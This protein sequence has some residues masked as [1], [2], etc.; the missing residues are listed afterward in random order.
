VY[1]AGVIEDRVGA[2]TFAVRLLLPP[3]SPGLPRS[4]PTTRS[5]ALQAHANDL[6]LAVPGE[7]ADD[8]AP[9]NLV[10]LP[11]A[12]E[13][14]VLHALRLRYER[15]DRAT[16]VGDTLVLLGADPP[17]DDVREMLSTRWRASRRDGAVS[18][19]LGA[20]AVADAASGRAAADRAA[21]AD[22]RS[23]D[24]G[25]GDDH[26]GSA[27][28]VFEAAEVALARA[29]REGAG[30]S[31]VLLGEAG[32]G[33]TRAAAAVVQYVARGLDLAQVVDEA[34]RDAAEEVLEA[35]GEAGAPVGGLSPEVLLGRLPASTPAGRSPSEADA[36]A[37]ATT[38]WTRSTDGAAAEPGSGHSASVRDAVRRSVAHATTSFRAVMTLRPGSAGRDASAAPS[39]LPSA[40]RLERILAAAT[41][42]RLAEAADVLPVPDLAAR[43]AAADVVVSSFTRAATSS[44]PDSSRCAVLTRVFVAVGRGGVPAC[45]SPLAP[46]TLDA[47]A[48][49]GAPVAAR[50]DVSPVDTER[51]TH[52]PPGERSF[53]AFYQLCAGLDAADA[54]RLC[55]P[56]ARHCRVLHRGGVIDVSGGDGDTEADAAG[57]ARLDAA[58]AALGSSGD[59]RYGISHVLAAILALG[60]V[61][62]VPS[63]QSSGAGRAG[64]HA[65]PLPP[66]AAARLQAS[67]V[68]ASDDGISDEHLACVAVPPDAAPDGSSP[69]E[70]RRLHE[71]HWA[72]R[73]FDEAA[74]LLGLPRGRLAALLTRKTQPRPSSTSSRSPAAVPLLVAQAE[75]RRDR[76][77]RALYGA[78]LDFVVSRVNA[79]LGADHPAVAIATSAA[80][81]GGPAGYRAEVRRAAAAGSAAADGA[82][83]SGAGARSGALPEEARRAVARVLASGATGVGPVPGSIEGAEDGAA[84]VASR[85]AAVSV[86]DVPGFDSRPVRSEF[87]PP[88]D[89][90]FDP[91]SVAAGG[92]SGLGRN[93][94]WQLLRNYGAERSESLFAANRV[95]DRAELLDGEGLLRGARPS[96]S[97]ASHR[98]LDGHGVHGRG[99]GPGPDGPYGLESNEG[100]LSLLDAP[101]IGLLG[102]L[103]ESMQYAASSDADVLKKL[104]TMHRRSHCLNRL[105]EPLERVAAATLAEEYMTAEDAVTALYGSAVVGAAPGADPD[106]SA[107]D[108]RA[109]AHAVVVRQ[110]QH[111][112]ALRHSQGHTPYDSL[113]MLASNR[114]GTC[115]LSICEAVMAAGPA[116]HALVPLLGSVMRAQTLRGAAPD[117]DLAGPSAGRARGGA[118]GGRRHGP[119]AAA[120]VPG[121]GAPSVFD[122]LDTVRRRGDGDVA[123][124]GTQAPRAHDAVAKLVHLLDIAAGASAEPLYVRCLLPRYGRPFPA[125]DETSAAVAAAAVA[126]KALAHQ[127]RCQSLVPA[128]R[129]AKEG[130]SQ[131][132]LFADFY[133]VFVVVLPRSASSHLPLACPRSATPLEGRT[134]CE[135][136]VV[137][138]WREYSGAL[139]GLDRDSQVQLG[140]TRV[141]LRREAAAALDTLRSVRRSAMDSAAVRV[142]AFM[143]GASGRAQHVVARHGVTRLQAAVRGRPVRARFL[144]QRGAATAIG[145]VWRGHAA[146][147]AYRRARAGLSR[148]KACWAGRKA[149]LAYLHGLRTLRQL[150]AAAAGALLRRQLLQRYEAAVAIQRS[151]RGFLGRNREFW[152]EVH[153]SLL[154]Q[155][156][157]RGF[158]WRRNNRHL[159]LFV[160]KRVVARLAV[161]R[162]ARVQAVVRGTGVRRA[163]R[164][165]RGSAVKVQRW[166]RAMLLWRGL[167]VMREAAVAVQR[168]MRTAVFRQR[169]RGSRERRMLAE[170]SWRTMQAREQETSQL[171]H[172]LHRV[173]RINA[174]KH[175]RLRERLSESRRAE[176]VKDKW[177][178]SFA[179]FGRVAD[180]MPERDREHVAHEHYVARD[181]LVIDV[182][183]V[184]SV[185]HSYPGGWT[186]GLS[187][188]DAALRERGQ[189]VQTVAL[190]SHHTAVLSSE[191]HVYTWGM[192]DRHQLG[193]GYARRRVQ[194]TAEE[195]RRVRHAQAFRSTASAS[196]ARDGKSQRRRSRSTGPLRNGFHETTSSRAAAVAQTVGVPLEDIREEEDAAGVPVS[197]RRDITGGRPLA[198]AL[199]DT[200]RLIRRMSSTRMGSPSGARGPMTAPNFSPAGRA[201]SFRFSPE[202]TGDAAA[203]NAP[204]ALHLAGAN[205]SAMRRRPSALNF[206]GRDSYTRA[207]APGT[208]AASTAHILAARSP[209]VGSPGSSRGASPPPA[210]MRVSSAG[211]VASGRSRSVTPRARSRRASRAVTTKGASHMDTGAASLVLGRTGSMR[212]RAA[213]IRVSDSATSARR[214]SGGYDDDSSVGTDHA[215]VVSNAED[216]LGAPRGMGQRRT[217]RVWAVGGTTG[218]PRVGGGGGGAGSVHR[219]WAPSEASEAAEPDGPTILD[220]RV[221][222]TRRHADGVQ[223]P[224]VVTGLRYEPGVQ[225]TPLRYLTEGVKVTAIAAGADHT[226]ALT[227]SG[228]VMAWGSN[229]RGQL[230]LSHREATSEPTEVPGLRGKRVIQIG[231]GPRHSMAVTHGGLLF[232]WGAGEYTGHGNAALL[233]PKERFSEAAVASAVNAA[234]AR[235]EALDDVENPH[236][237]LFS[238]VAGAFKNRTAEATVSGGGEGGASGRFVPGGHRMGVWGSSGGRRGSVTTAGASDDV[239]GEAEARAAAKAERRLR[240]WKAPDR[241]EPAAVRSL[242]RHHVKKVV[243][244]WGF[245]LALTLQGRVFGWGDNS[246]GRLGV[247]TPHADMGDGCAEFEP[248]PVSVWPPAALEA[249]EELVAAEEDEGLL[250]AHHADGGAAG[251]DITAGGSASSPGRRSTSGRSVGTRGSDGQTHGGD[252]MRLSTK[253]ELIEAGRDGASTTGGGAL[254]PPSTRRE[255]RVYFDMPVQMPSPQQRARRREQDEQRKVDE[256]LEARR[257]AARGEPAPASA[258]RAGGAGERKTAEEDEDISSALLDRD[259]PL[260]EGSEE[261][262]F[263]GAALDVVAGGSHAMVLTSMGGVWSWGGN[264][265]GQLGLGHFE[266][267]H[268]PSLVRALAG[269]GV[270]SIAAGWRH[271]LAV[272]DGGVVAWGHTAAVPAVTPIPMPPPPPGVREGDGDDDGDEWAGAGPARGRLDLTHAVSPLPLESPFRTSHRTALTAMSSFSH[273]LSVSVITYTELLLGHDPRKPP[274]TAVERAQG[275]LQLWKRHERELQG[276]GAGQSRGLAALAAVAATLEDELD[277]GEADGAEDS[278][279]AG[280]VPDQLR[281]DGYITGGRRL[282]VAGYVD[283]YVTRVRASLPVTPAQ[284]AAAAEAGTD[285]H[286][287]IRRTGSSARVAAAM[288]GPA[289]MDVSGRAAAGARGVSVSSKRGDFARRTMGQRRPTLSFLTPAS[290]AP[291]GL[292]GSGRK[293]PGSRSAIAAAAAASAK[294]AAPPAPP[295]HPSEKRSLFA[296]QPTA[297]VRAGLAGPGSAEAADTAEQRRRRHAEDAFAAMTAAAVSAD[298]ER[299][300][301]EA[302]TSI[303]G[304]AQQVAG[305]ISGRWLAAGL[306]KYMNKHSGQAKARRAAEAGRVR[307]EASAVTLPGLLHAAA[308]AHAANVAR[309]AASRGLSDEEASAEAARAMLAGEASAR[310]TA[311]SA[312]FLRSAVGRSVGGGARGEPREGGPPYPRAASS[313]DAG[314]VGGPAPRT[315][316]GTAAPSSLGAAAAGAAMAPSSGGGGW[317]VALAGDDEVLEGHGGSILALLASLRRRRLEAASA[318]MAARRGQTMRR[319]GEDEG[320]DPTALLQVQAAVS[321]GDVGALVAA[322]VNPSA[323]AE[324]GAELVRRMRAEVA[325]ASTAVVASRPAAMSS[326]LAAR[327]PVLSSRAV[328]VLI[329]RIRLRRARDASAR[330]T[331]LERLSLLPSRAIEAAAIAARAVVRDP[332]LAS[333]PEAELRS[334]LMEAAAIEEASIDDVALADAQAASAL[335]S[336]ALRHIARHPG[337]VTR[338]SAEDAED[339][340]PAVVAFGGGPGRHWREPGLSVADVARDPMS[341]A[342]GGADLAARTGRRATRREAAVAAAA[343]THTGVRLGGASSDPFMQV[344]ATGFGRAGFDRHGQR[345]DAEAEAQ[346]LMTWREQEREAASRRALR[347]IGLQ[348]EAERALRSRARSTAAGRA[349]S[350]SL[351]RKFDPSQFPLP[352]SWMGRRPASSAMAAQGDTEAGGGF[353]P[354]RGRGVRP[355]DASIDSRA[356]GVAEQPV[357][358]DEKRLAWRNKARLA[359]SSTA[360]AVAGGGEG[361]QLGS[362]PAPAWAGHAARAVRGVGPDGS[363]DDGPPPPPPAAGADG[364]LAVA[365]RSVR[366]GAPGRMGPSDVDAAI[367]HEMS[368]RQPGRHEGQLGAWDGVLTGGSARGSRDALSSAIRGAADAHWSRGGMGTTVATGMTQGASTVGGP[369]GVAMGDLM[370]P[371]ASGGGGGRA[372]AGPDDGRGAR[373]ATMAS[374]RSAASARAPVSLSYD[375]EDLEPDEGGAY[376]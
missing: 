68:T 362:A 369:P 290:A 260:P 228:R 39:G 6:F 272:V 104:A 350:V 285:V 200:A 372:R 244:G 87:N 5:G 256:E 332:S 141:F 140:R 243:S 251:H 44:A 190:G 143:R 295:R 326:Q 281:D 328:A 123:V 29:V 111:L 218:S 280:S 318:A 131:H 245:T 101:S 212:L 232:T 186:K 79:G 122:S 166:L 153:A 25:L 145:A 136:L 307:R 250:I 178:F 305:P 13:A 188:L 152:G 324:A 109:R 1:I 296:H 69:A 255:K 106:S 30:Q 288:T 126:P 158:S 351:L 222:T 130:F 271:S 236:H 308:I 213:G 24:D 275:R 164:E 121:A 357:T 187:D 367:E 224:T 170:H 291:L 345:F 342:W 325:G 258:G 246:N 7:D 8:E 142:Q 231:A 83:A 267:S 189:T 184:T 36:G 292:G 306:M 59:E 58:L 75:D 339:G 82:T 331:P 323:A 360:A 129:A 302:V 348:R 97:A 32:A 195:S 11:H 183:A 46:G 139:A 199:G 74:G 162:V 336:A 376:R 92:G 70:V 49:P 364:P 98:G 117:A 223:I 99:A 20:I 371:R 270:D 268:R 303:P 65:L 71:S 72:G 95:A 278:D 374:Q 50:V 287:R 76:L 341:L 137:A 93:G 219:G 144:R 191:G 169:L 127:L 338:V 363:D 167:R 55:V 196:A 48:A 67:V 238:P 16:W 335:R 43:L 138:L 340:V 297:A 80:G 94:L 35:L 205:A 279:E 274:V 316:R 293:P 120:G 12:H 215:S 206:S 317:D 157:W 173:A 156:C 248:L 146:R 21:V 27:P 61:Q 282:P 73:R 53:H 56:E 353:D 176:A 337:D 235:G 298:A 175:R 361:F 263:A 81:V 330:T 180:G 239:D 310:R 276:S 344:S 257:A 304:L 161:L 194:M 22:A 230:G 193:H 334:R 352:S 115:P 277:A 283:S 28:T 14:G 54:A 124:E 66:L 172:H 210:L 45:P 356:M 259:I 321:G 221:V 149:R 15:G 64:S 177:G 133:D 355:M 294:P 266:D 265:F 100:V 78:L 284:A 309:R 254:R 249:G 185:D 242:G 216:A 273:T 234:M 23:G 17:A 4:A 116:A 311:R 313:S 370:P 226:V 19:S 155:A 151:G 31:V 204:S 358:E 343:A 247:G 3:G 171:V 192:N 202:M 107:H 349:T 41:H 40:A 85:L 154:L 252:T 237:P 9:N 34:G 174:A 38:A 112:F 102:I 300:V 346:N 261:A 269:V 47:P 220:T 119:A 26:S 208:A 135:S 322:G 113:G 286:S 159:V 2:E 241:L 365:T 63:E 373:S 110:M 359:A 57:F 89:A 182:D 299:E 227:A 108:R 225:R 52:T 42:E 253:A 320:G 301:I 209:R 203:G 91:T 96:P 103:Q 329:R 289:S 86:L 60:D 148:I 150:Q 165:L 125:H 18:A 132:A 333:M 179:G 262:D 114:S 118:A 366:G 147:L 62:I 375:P 181:A 160:R 84:S 197:Q 240:Q 37:P 90:A 88:P 168:M 217:S 214:R 163:Y 312:A 207:A 105:A 233:D 264:A 347:L 354:G 327:G 51:V 128:L 77:M 198:G 134:M 315:R 319:V 10:D 368:M 211:S 33:K 314:S 201:G 229:A